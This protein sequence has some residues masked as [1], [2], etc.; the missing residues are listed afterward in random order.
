V[1]TLTTGLERIIHVYTPTSQRGFDVAE[2]RDCQYIELPSISI[3]DRAWVNPID[4]GLYILQTPPHVVL[5]VA[6]ATL[7]ENKKSYP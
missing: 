5:D 4:P 6:E 3:V 2:G 7:K 1:H